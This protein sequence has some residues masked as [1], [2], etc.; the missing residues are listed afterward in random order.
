MLH[1]QEESNADQSEVVGIAVFNQT[2][3]LT[4]YDAIVQN[5]GF[6]GTL[7]Y[8]NHAFHIVDFEGMRTVGDK[9]HIEKIKAVK[10]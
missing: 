7:E 9:L 4:A 1:W 6:N 10:G 2:T 3:T 8:E 5:D